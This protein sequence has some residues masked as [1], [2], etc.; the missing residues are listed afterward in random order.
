MQNSHIERGDQ[1]TKTV[2]RKYRPRMKLS[3]CCAGSNS[4]MMDDAERLC[5]LLNSSI[6]KTIRSLESHGKHDIGGLI[7]F[8]FRTHNK[9]LPLCAGKGSL[10]RD[11][12]EFETGFS[13]GIPF[14][15]RIPKNNDLAEVSISLLISDTK[16]SGEYDA[17]GRKIELIKLA[18][19]IVNRTARN[20]IMG[21]TVDDD[22]AIACTVTSIIKSFQRDSFHLKDL[23]SLCD[24][25]GIQ[26][27]SII[28]DTLADLITSNIVSVDESWSANGSRVNEQTCYTVADL[29]PQWQKYI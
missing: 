15:Y 26:D 12:D 20:I 25:Y 1:M 29:R 23:Y 10:F 24:A 13:R 16:A 27:R 18:D 8:G 21:Y 4:K 17:Q 6:R 14:Y 5:L 19:E 11:N 2:A 7:R 28:D 22:K 3:Y 9:K